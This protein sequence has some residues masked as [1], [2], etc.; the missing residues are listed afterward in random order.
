MQTSYGSS[1]EGL[2]TNV[3]MPALEV[4]TVD[5]C[6]WWCAD[7]WSK[8]D[9]VLNELNVQSVVTAPAHD[10][11][12][13]L[14][15]QGTYTVKGFAYSGQISP[16]VSCYSQTLWHSLQVPNMYSSVHITTLM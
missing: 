2:C 4:S 16:L 1:V 5:W 13:A 12:I 9:F 7:W 3:C 8:S 15:A 11:M 10:E 14:T 6:T